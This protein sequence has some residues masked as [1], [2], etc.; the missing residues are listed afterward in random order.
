MVVST[1]TTKQDRHPNSG[2]LRVNF[3]NNKANFRYLTP[4]ECFIL[5]GFS[6][7]DYDKVI[8]NNFHTKKNAKMFTR[9]NLIKMAGNSIAVNVLEAVFRQV[10][11]LD[12]RL[13]I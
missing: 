3:D 1:L 2:N 7:E 4:R 12:N 8:S 13:Y 10:V 11:E 6:E 9:D 5:M